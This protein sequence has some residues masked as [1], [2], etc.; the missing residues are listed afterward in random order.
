M[1]ADEIIQQ[2]EWS[3]LNAAEK[4][5]L[6]ELA[7]NEQEYNLVKKMLQI[8]AEEPGDVPMIG[9]HVRHELHAELPKSEVRPI[10]FYKYAAA[11][12]IL[13]AVITG[14]IFLKKDKQTRDIVKNDT[15][16][17][18]VEQVAIRQ[19]PI[20]TAIDTAASSPK[21][22]VP[23]QQQNVVNL[24]PA[25]TRVI[26]DPVPQEPVYA[27]V[28]TSVKSHDELLDLVTEIY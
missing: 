2:K 13:I 7:S 12:A 10:V 27:V 18:P 24:V 3:E 17:R 11:A 4:V 22:I 26:A 8:F 20:V 1:Q 25:P 9:K 15:I 16:A 5:L 19:Q 28:S 14:V 6:L 21:S 23:S